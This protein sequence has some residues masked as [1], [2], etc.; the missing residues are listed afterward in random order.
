[1]EYEDIDI[2]S[3][4]QTALTQDCSYLVAMSILLWDHALTFDQEIQYIWA[5]KK[6][7]SAYLF[8][9]VRYGVIVANLPHLIF[10]YAP[11]SLTVRDPIWLRNA[12]SSLLRIRSVCCSRNWWCLVLI[13][14]GRV[15]A[16]SGR[17]RRLLLSIILIAISLVGLTAWSL[18]Q[19]QRGYPIT[20]VPGCHLGV[21]QLGASRGF[22]YLAPQSF[23]LI[24]S[25]RPQ[26]LL[27]LPVHLRHDYF[28]ADALFWKRF[29]T[30][31]RRA[32]AYA[33]AS[34]SS[35]RWCAV[36]YGTMALANLAN[37]V[38]FLTPNRHIRGTLA[39]FATCFSVTM[40]V[41]LMLNIHGRSED[42]ILNDDNLSRIVAAFNLEPVSDPE[43]D[44][45][46]I[47]EEPRARDS[48]SRS[49]AGL[50]RSGIGSPHRDE[51]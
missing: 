23:G 2:V 44:H 7:M 45:D 6:R 15:Y 4:A 30:G 1:M 48:H 37:I 11:I 38:T 27:D 34:R 51:G 20:V 39:S 24:C 41:R 17:N 31:S 19:G 47:R 5:R 36:Y 49:P 42:G 8:L 35:F 33:F 13:M 12:I 25:H 28:R 43:S 32:D 46:L 26:H 18:R 50:V 40:L 9:V 14:I 10:I 29:S 16:L 22:R 3:Q 21:S